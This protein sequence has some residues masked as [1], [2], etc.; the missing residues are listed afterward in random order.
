MKILLITLMLFSFSTTTYAK[1]TD[2]NG[3]E[4]KALKTTDGY[5][6]TT[7]TIQSNIDNL[8][9]HT[10]IVMLQKDGQAF[11]GAGIAI[12]KRH[13]LTVNHGSASTGGNNYYLSEENGTPYDATV[14]KSD[15][16][17]DIALLEI[18]SRAPDLP[19]SMTFATEIKA[20]E[21]IYTIG[22]PL[23]GLYSLTK[24]KTSNA[25][26]RLNLKVSDGNSGG[27]VINEQGELLGMVTSKQNQVGNL[28]Y[29][30][31]FEDL[32]SFLQND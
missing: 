28:A 19:E 21:T 15:S 18:D 32:K 29:M 11:R 8:K 12:D 4:R 31:T 25:T 9:S 27:F 10:V 14:T 7:E 2:C 17:K 30:V 20:S 24:G 26:G 16:T 13:I 23:S 1:V 5:L 3:N 22:H 6:Y